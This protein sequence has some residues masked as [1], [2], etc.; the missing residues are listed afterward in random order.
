MVLSLRNATM[1]CTAG[2]ILVTAMVSLMVAV[3][4]TNVVLNKTNK[5]NSLVV[6]ECFAEHQ[7][8]TKSSFNKVLTERSKGVLT[9]IQS[10]LNVARTAQKDLERAARGIPLEKL[11]DP[12][13]LNRVRKVYLSYFSTRETT[14]MGFSQY[15]GVGF[16]VAGTSPDGGINSELLYKSLLTNYGSIF[17]KLGTVNFNESGYFHDQ[18]CAGFA[19]ITTTKSGIC[20]IPFNLSQIPIFSF[21]VNPGQTKWTVIMGFSTFAGSTLITGIVPDGSTENKVVGLTFTSFSTSEITVFLQS[22]K[23]N[24]DE[25]LFISSSGNRDD[26][27]RGLLVGVSAG[28]ATENKLGTDPTSG[29]ENQLVKLPLHCTRATDRIIAESCKAIYAD[30]PL[31]TE[32]FEYYYN[33]Q[34][35]IGSARELEID[36]VGDGSKK[37]F[38]IHLTRLTDEFGL[39][40][41]VIISIDQKVV[42][43]E[44]ERQKREAADTILSTK[45]S[46]KEELQGSRGILY[47]AVSGTTIVLILLAFLSSRYITRPLQKLSREM[48][49]VAELR[50]DNVATFGSASWLTEVYSM[51][52]SFTSM[53][54]AMIEYR[55]YLPDTLG[56]DDE[57]YEEE[58]VSANG[59]TTE[60]ATSASK[61]SLRNR[62]SSIPDKQMFS[63]KVGITSTGLTLTAKRA[64]THVRVGN[65]N[66][67][68]FIR[69]NGDPDF[70]VGYHSEWLLSVVVEAKVLRGVIERFI[71]DNIY[72]SFGALQTCTMP[73]TKAGRF[74]LA[75]RERAS[76]GLSE[77][78]RRTG[79]TYEGD[80]YTVV[81]VSTGSTLSGNLGCQGFKAPSTLGKSV[82]TAHSMQTVAR[83][84]GLDIIVDERTAEEMCGGFVTVPVDIVFH[85]GNKNRITCFY[86]RGKQT[87]DTVGE[88]MYAMQSDNNAYGRA[89]NTLL[90]GDLQQACT[91]F[92]E[93]PNDDVAVQVAARL[94]LYI[95]DVA[96][97]TKKIPGDYVR[98]QT[99]GNL[100]VPVV[101][102]V[103][104]STPTVNPIN[105]SVFT[106]E[107]KPS[108]G[109]MVQREASQSS[110]SMSIQRIGTV[111][112]APSSRYQSSIAVSAS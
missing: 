52:S 18:P 43:G 91:E 27:Q 48:Q 70:I 101:K 63:P 82:L 7:K 111:S 23:L 37:L 50:L 86:L 45:E 103:E 9:K 71:A 34:Q 2:C 13:E 1:A 55:Q 38:S 66:F 8:Q 76:R 41:W 72:I 62:G 102:F 99:S 26:D 64:V 80:N 87:K 5:G 100:P 73:T 89:W 78:L 81:G 29:L 3:T 14:V 92:Q 96:R 47:I 49:N 57:E 51:E 33:L 15:N 93:L 56:A 88:W 106:L 85:K 94:R 53:V 59:S 4:S 112:S 40:W 28:N 60:T 54:A 104:S 65:R 11:S 17:T 79:I 109:S 97:V 77:Y 67:G 10:M 24:E 31:G 108:M 19:H 58:E 35:H 25:R 98:V 83:E 107:S 42:I 21:P 105:V 90:A 20:E 30:A 39:N 12:E 16:V 46:A 69:R 75:I 61:N 84:I 22:L 95:D 110:S 68:S 6:D 36:S 74:C 44:V 32:P